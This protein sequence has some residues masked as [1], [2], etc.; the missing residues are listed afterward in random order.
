MAEMG[1]RSGWYL[2]LY[3][4]ED[5]ETSYYVGTTIY[6]QLICGGYGNPK[7]TVEWAKRKLPTVLAGAS[8]SPSEPVL[9]YFGSNLI[10]FRRR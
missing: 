2:R 5:V 10:A 9:V 8:R 4:I 6:S 1:E 3:V 7:T